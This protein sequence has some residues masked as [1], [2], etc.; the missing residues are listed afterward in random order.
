MVIRIISLSEVKPTAQRIA[1]AGENKVW[2]WQTAEAHKQAQKTR[3]QNAQ[4]PAPAYVAGVHVAKHPVRA[5]LGGL[6]IRM[7]KY[8]PIYI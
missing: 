6:Q 1:A 3:T 8:L 5:V 7:I 4:P 2:K